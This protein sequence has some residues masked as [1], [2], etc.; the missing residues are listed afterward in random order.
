MEDEELTGEAEAEKDAAPVSGGLF[1]ADSVVTGKLEADFVEP[2][3]DE[4]L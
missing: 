1:V 4:G 3:D 2:A